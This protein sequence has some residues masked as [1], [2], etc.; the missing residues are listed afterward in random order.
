MKQSEMLALLK[1]LSSDLLRYAAG[2]DSIVP[3]AYAEALDA[4]IETLDRM[5]WISVKDRL[6]EVE[7][8]VLVRTQWRCGNE[9]YSTTATA[10]YEDGTVLEDNSR[11]NWSEIWEWGI[12]DEEKDG[13]KIPQGWWESS[14]YIH[15]DHYNNIDDEVTHWMP[16]PELPEGENNG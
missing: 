11:W 3:G 6:P 5:T 13:Y 2:S 12:Y 4:A 1:E 10:F 8:E 9:T 7:T 15:D 14:H 16:L